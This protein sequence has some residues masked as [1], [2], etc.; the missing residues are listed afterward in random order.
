[1]TSVYAETNGRYCLLS[2]Q[3]HATGSEQVCAA[4]SGLVYALAGYLVNAANEQRALLYQERLESGDVLLEFSGDD[5]AS[6]AF[7]MTVIGLRQIEKQFPDMVT[8]EI[9]E[10]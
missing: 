5:R 9:L 2:I 4:V 8:V 1:M 10:K 6:A 7:E 3:G